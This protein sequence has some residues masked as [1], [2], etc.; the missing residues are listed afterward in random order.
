MQNLPHSSSDKREDSKKCGERG[1][2]IEKRDE[3]REG[4]GAE[5]SAVKDG[6]VEERRRGGVE[7]A[8]KKT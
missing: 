8:R 1:R 7:G 6:V 4:A 3:G 2:R 5:K